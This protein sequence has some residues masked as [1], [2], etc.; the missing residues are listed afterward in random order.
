MAKSVSRP[1]NG[2]STTGKPS[3]GGRGNNPPA[4]PKPGNT[5]K[6]KR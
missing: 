6:P 4:P 3:G 1:P 5:S 2:P